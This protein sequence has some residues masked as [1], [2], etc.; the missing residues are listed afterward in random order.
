MRVDLG[1]AIRAPHR[2]S[3]AQLQAL[4]PFVSEQGLGIRG[5][6]IGHE[7][8]GAPFYFDPI[9]MHNVGELRL[10][11]P[12]LCIFGEI[13]NGKSTLVK[14]L[15][16]RLSVFGYQ[17]IYV[18]AKAEVAPV[19][20]A[21]GVA[22]LRPTPG[23]EL[24]LNP[25]DARLRVGEDDDPV[26]HRD[27]LLRSIVGLMLDRALGAG[28]QRA[29]TETMQALSVERPVLTLPAVQAA[30]EERAV[31]Q[32]QL[33]VL[34]DTLWNYTHGAARGLFDAETSTAVDTEAPLLAV[35]LSGML[36]P[37]ADVRVR[38]VTMALT[39]AWLYATIATGPRRRLLVI[40]EAWFLLRDAATIE[41]LR[42]Q[43]K[44]CRTLGTA[45]VAVVHHPSDLSVE[46]AE[47]VATDCRTR[48]FFA[49]P[50]TERPALVRLGLTEAEADYVCALPPHWSLWKVADRTFVVHVD[51][52]ESELEMVDTEAAMRVPPLAV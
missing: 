3:T 18:S 4:F 43:W 20:A 11:D 6:W 37:G 52:Q 7:L 31:D 36:L 12:N 15:C 48:I 33:Q 17:P 1:A 47:A 10:T 27:L 2:A 30:L 35:D 38:A 46:G 39:A 8:F 23:G 32:P 5:A 25:L 41:W 19:A 40:D 42:A 50:T 21:F 29:L 44:L 51:V 14:A 45:N 49:Q 16:R 28:E 13:G 9:E 22:T 34:A 26:R 24:R